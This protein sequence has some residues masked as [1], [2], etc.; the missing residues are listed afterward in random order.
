[1]LTFENNENE[2]FGLSKDY[3]SSAGDYT[4][5]L[6]RMGTNK[7]ILEAMN[8]TD[9]DKSFT[10]MNRMDHSFQQPSGGVR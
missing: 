6:Q 5:G 7:T 2:S 4:R 3:A 10:S 8:E 1:M 9:F